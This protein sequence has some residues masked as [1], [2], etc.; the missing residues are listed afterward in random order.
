MDRICYGLRINRMGYERLR[1]IQEPGVLLS[2]DEYHLYAKSFVPNHTGELDAV[3]L[4]RPEIQSCDEHPDMR[5]DCIKCHKRVGKAGGFIS[6][7]THGRHQH[8][9]RVVL[10]M[11]NDHRRCHED[12]PIDRAVACG[13]LLLTP[14]DF[15]RAIFL[16]QRCRPDS[17]NRELIASVLGCTM[18]QAALTALAI[19]ASL[20][21]QLKSGGVHLGMDRAPCEM[22]EPGELV[23][24]LPKQDK[25]N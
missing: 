15:N 16:R 22:G 1:A 20:I 18:A 12:P 2:P 7:G 11:N 17:E 10:L 24:M 3:Q 19:I 13:S 5:C 6:C 14:F 21:E 23:Q 8:L 25:C 9:S 4:V